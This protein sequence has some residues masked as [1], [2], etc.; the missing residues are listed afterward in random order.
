M[1]AKLGL[2]HPSLGLAFTEEFRGIDTGDDVI[3]AMAAADIRDAFVKKAN[4]LLGNVALDS[5][6]LN[7]D[8][9]RE[10]LAGDPI[11]CLGVDAE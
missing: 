4:V 10:N 3:E 2:L 1:D 5:L 6:H 11:C 8:G 7:C 9:C